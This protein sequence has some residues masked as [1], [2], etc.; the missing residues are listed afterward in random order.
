MNEKTEK[1]DFKKFL[2]KSWFFIGIFVIVIVA[3]IVLMSDRK[4]EYSGEVDYD[5][6]FYYI[7]GN[8]LY[9]KEQGRDEVLVSA[10]MFMNPSSRRPEEALDAVLISPDGQY[11]YFFENVE[12]KNKIGMIGDFCV[13]YEGRKKLIEKDMGI[14]FAASADS[15][16]IAFIKTLYGVEGGSGYQNVRHD[17]Y[18]YSIKE[19][20]KRIEK[21]VQP[22]WLN[23]S[24]DGKSIIYTK[25]YDAATDTSS[26]FMNRDGET[27]F[28][29]DNMFFYGNYVPLGTH[30]INWP[31]VNYDASK[32]IYGKRLKYGE[33]ADMYLY[34]E[35]KN[36]LLGERVHQIYTDDD[37]KSALIVDDFSYD[38][39]VGVMSRINL[40][41]MQKEKIVEDVWALGH[42]EV[43]K[44]T[45]TEFINSNLYFKN[46]DD[47]LNVAD[48][49]IMTP[50][51]EK[52]ILNATD[53]SN[54]Y[55]SD[56]FK[57]IYGLNYYIEEEGGRVIKTK[58]DENDI[59]DVQKFD[60]MVRDIYSSDSGKYV[61][62][63][64]DDDFFIIGDDN[65]KTHIGKLK[66]ETLEF[67]N[68]E[69]ILYF[70][71]ETGLSL[72]NVII[73]ELEVSQDNILV[74][75][76]A[77]YVWKYG[78]DKLAFLTHFDFAKKTGTM[79]LTDLK[80]KYELMVEN[81]ELPLLYN[82]I[83]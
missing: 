55:Y 8:N 34:S 73:R 9:I 46:Y 64:L 48:L 7:T 29:D 24:G 82:Y 22:N 63:M 57:T 72:G 53:I 23:I 68:N 65:K 11:L 30:K 54:I 71:A 12:I 26:L 10:N 3:L 58:I 27:I 28:I 2:S 38:E 17:L 44:I 69:E 83:Q 49:C 79:Y 56:D 80:G 59:V 66:I 39:I 52:I 70:F 40:D 42:V 15:S 50:E 75:E 61:T 81:V 4:T 51:G 5:M 6:P 43:A 41:T 25:F 45:N 1:F 37:F 21:D 16:K 13:Y 20:K 19:G 77:Q 60:K 67:L 33:L 32:I 47:Y 31:L 14:Y 35:G 78:E 76:N 74:A 62:Y 18:T 36:T